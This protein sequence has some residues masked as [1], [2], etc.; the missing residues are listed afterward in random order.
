V[1]RVVVTGIG[2]TS[3]LGCDPEGFF[4]NLVAGR[5]GIRKL[6]APWAVNAHAGTVEVDL[7]VHFPKVRRIGMDRISMLALLAARQA[8]AASGLAIDDA[9]AERTGL[10]WGTG[11]G[12]AGTL[13]G[14]YQDLL[15]RKAARLKPSTIVSV[16]TNAATG[17]IGIEFGIRGPACTYSSACSSSAVAIGEAFRAIR[18]GVVDRALTGGA[19]A[20]L[21]EGVVKAWESLGTLARP[22]P[23]RPETSCRPFAADRS[24][25]LL[26]EGAVVLVLE[27]ESMARGRGANILAEISGYGN[28]NDASHITQPD[29]SGQ[30]R[31]MRLALAEA[32]VAPQ[33]I[34]HINAHG[35]GT[36]AGD[37]SET[38]AIRQV[39]GGHAGRIP[40]SATKALHGH[41]M[42]ATGALEFVATVLALRNAV[43]PPTAHL[44]NPDPECDLDY[45]PHEARPLA[46][47]E[48]AV[49]NSFGFGGDNAVLVAR[50]YHL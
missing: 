33:S 42:G 32:G 3:P 7:D 43:A 41:L 47:A 29:A 11:M 31:A 6:D 17:Q 1:K 2:V 22:D 44:W 23:A 26:A 13:E 8:Q 14:A 9:N 10:Y 16:M 49:S 35:T 36:K 18:F 50:R 21:T 24:G 37:I 15:V 34:D 12:G 25:F 4:A 48:W 5:S 19:E 40:I 39:F 45:V 20:L 30:A 38:N 27:E 28:T 46:R